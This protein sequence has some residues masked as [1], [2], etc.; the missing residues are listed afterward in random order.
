[1]CDGKPLRGSAQLQPGKEEKE[2]QEESGKGGKLEV[3][4]PGQEKTAEAT[5]LE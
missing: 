5:T 1:M 4:E 3:H 2:R